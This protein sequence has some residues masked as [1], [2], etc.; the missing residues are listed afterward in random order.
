MGKCIFAVCCLIYIAIITAVIIYVPWVAW[1][2]GVVSICFVFIA[3]V[4]CYTKI[5]IFFIYIYCAYIF[6]VVM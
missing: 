1:V 2:I 5:G 4:N 3:F 6:I